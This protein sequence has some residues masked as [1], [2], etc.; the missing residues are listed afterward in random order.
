MMK[1]LGRIISALVVG[2]AG[3]FFILLNLVWGLLVP[4][5]IAYAIYYNFIKQ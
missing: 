2:A 5:M 3:I 4:V 1:K